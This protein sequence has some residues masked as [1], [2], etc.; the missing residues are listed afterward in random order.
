MDRASQLLHIIDEHEHSQQL[1]RPT[2]AAA[3]TVTA[4]GGGWTP[5]NFSNDIIAADDIDKPFDLH[6]IVISNADSNV[7]YEIVLY[8]GPNDVECARVRFG[9]TAVFTNSITLPLQTI[10]LPANSRIRAKSMDG[11]GGAAC[12]I[13]AVYLHTY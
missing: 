2:G 10:I 6:W 7:V 5:G 1:V 11:T 12:D 8:Y 9:R 4:G 3:I 13:V